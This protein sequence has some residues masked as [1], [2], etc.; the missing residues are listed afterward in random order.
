MEAVKMN[1]EFLEYLQICKEENVSIPVSTLTNA[2]Y[3]YILMKDGF[4]L[5]DDTDYF[6]SVM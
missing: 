1:K 6:V 5:S 3:N 4:I 2:Q